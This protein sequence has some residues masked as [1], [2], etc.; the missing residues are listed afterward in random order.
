MSLGLLFFKHTDKQG[1]FRYLVMVLAI[2]LAVAALLSSLALGNAMSA[3]RSRSAWVPQIAY[4][5]KLAVKLPLESNLSDKTLL[6]Y[7]ETNFDQYPTQKQKIYELGIRQINSN[8]PLIP[9]L[10]KQP[11]ENEMF[12]SPALLELIN[13]EPVLK[14]RYANYQLSLG[15]P[16][17]LLESPD[18]KLAIYKL[19]DNWIAQAEQNHDKT[20]KT[21]TAFG[22]SDLKYFS[23]VP[24]TKTQ[25]IIT[26]FMLICGLGVCFPMLILLISAMR[27]GMI[28]REQRYAA[29]SLIGTSKHQVNKIIL[30]EALA[31]T[32]IGVLLGAISYELIRIT[33]LA[34]ITFGKERFFLEDIKLNPSLYLGIIALVFLVVIFVNGIALRKVKSSPLG[35]VKIQKLPRKPSILGLIPLLV[36]AGSIWKLNQLGTTWYMQNAEIS[37]L[38]FAGT[39]VFIMIGLLTAGAFLTRLFADVLNLASR[40]MVGI[41]VAKRLQRFAKTIFS[42][43]SGVVL[44]LFVSSF[45]MT[46]L[47]S[48]EVTY[49]SL[50][51]EERA[52]FDL[53]Q[54]IRR[55]DTVEVNI[56]DHNNN[57]SNFLAELTQQPILAKNIKSHHQN[58]Y[59]VADVDSKNSKSG[60][61]YTCKDLEKLTKL[62]CPDHMQPD[63]QVILVRKYDEGVVDLSPFQS[64]MK[65]KIL[66]NSLTFS[67]KDAVSA[68]LGREY[69]RNIAYELNRTQGSDAYVQKPSGTLFD[70]LS[71]I[72]GL[73]QLIKLGTA[74]SII[75]AGFSVAVATIGGLFERKKSFSNL[76]LMGI[77]INQLGLVVLLESVLPML[78]ASV[79]AILA[80]VLAAKYFASVIAASTMLFA[81]PKLDYLSLVALALVG[82]IGVICLTLPILKQITSLEQNRTE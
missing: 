45:F 31:S 67:F 78:L 60:D 40:K 28:Q 36:A 50:K 6:T 59:F 1:W 56:E 8:S 48:V 66:H 21:I 11:A 23:E 71:N 61:L 53:E 57:H 37:M 46:T 65:G 75:V 81:W 41:M 32:S 33:V 55:D 76:H 27:I 73:V 43:V 4:N 64:T 5:D 12:V 69:L 35:V 13:R 82:A 74:L 26:T 70:A 17:T 72:A 25:M 3:H 10:K 80:G 63:R 47:A 44:A 79:G 18:T 7:D 15:V 42:S 68:N 49:N 16:Q 34:N 2:T 58:S 24:N 39:F 19:S 52:A 29:L 20:G 14:A 9:G 38:W 30:S 62:S 77:D 54:E 22:H 51:K